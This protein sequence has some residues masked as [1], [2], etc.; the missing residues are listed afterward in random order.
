[1]D[2]CF[3]HAVSSKP[4][5]NGERP[6]KSHGRR[7]NPIVAKSMKSERKTTEKPKPPLFTKILNKTK[8]TLFS[9]L[10]TESEWGSFIEFNGKC[11]EFTIEK[12]IEPILSRNPCEIPLNHRVLRGVWSDCTRFLFVP[13]CVHSF[14]SKAIFFSKFL[15]I[16]D[17]ILTLP[18]GQLKSIQKSIL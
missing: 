9:F 1:M 3:L 17:I 18:L 15:I 10:E 8:G 16:L 6:M 5:G 7:G 13:F 11:W 2:P 12:L 14:W 4:T